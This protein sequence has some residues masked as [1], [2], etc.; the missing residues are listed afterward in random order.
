M[1]RLNP[2]PNVESSDLQ[3]VCLMRFS[4]ES[5]NVLKRDISSDPEISALRE[6]IYSGW[7][8]KQKKVP[9]PLRKY[10]AYRDELSIENGLVLNG[11][12]VIIP[13]SQR[14]DILEK[15]HQTQ[16]GTAKC[17]LRAKSYFGLILTRTLK[18]KCRS[19]KVVKKSKTNK[20]KKHCN[21]LKYLLD[22]GKF[23][24]L[25]YSHGMRTKIYLYMIINLS[26]PFSRKYQVDSP[27]DKQL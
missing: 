15:I 25:I 7:P 13:E 14:D 24:V 1:S 8:E 17:K 12:R 4:D 22:H 6:I 20:S 11:E 3:K 16:Q 9:V 23:L 26:F 18:L 27:L 2:L 5:L 21:H 10:W 19:V